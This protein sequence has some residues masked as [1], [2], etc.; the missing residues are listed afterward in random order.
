MAEQSDTMNPSETER[1]DDDDDPFVALWAKREPANAEY[2]AI[3]SVHGSAVPGSD[4]YEELDKA[5]TA[6]G[7]RV[8]AIDQEIAD[9]VATTP[10]G[11]LTKLRIVWEQE[12]YNV[13]RDLADV[14]DADLDVEHLLLKGALYYAEQLAVAP[15]PDVIKRGVFDLDDLI[16]QSEDCSTTM[17]KLAEFVETDHVQQSML[18]VNTDLGSA[19][20]KMRRIFNDLHA[21]VVACN[22]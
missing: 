14:D 17:G 9:C 13:G 19:L 6:A 7:G 1:H 11:L 4:G 22:D 2:T 16:T 12:G 3:G 5:N 10:F 8:R 20:I 18:S 21:A 15:V